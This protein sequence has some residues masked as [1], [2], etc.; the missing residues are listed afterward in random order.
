MAFV[1]GSLN[2]SFSQL[3]LQD[4]P[5]S[6]KICF[7]GVRYFLTSKSIANLVANVTM[8]DTYQAIDW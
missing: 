6:K 3:N 8:E 7:K 5:L 4:I 1:I 2:A